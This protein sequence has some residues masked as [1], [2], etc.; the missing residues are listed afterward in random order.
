MIEFDIE[1][2]FEIGYLIDKE[3][4]VYSNQNPAQI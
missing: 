1:E 2:E 3:G 4:K